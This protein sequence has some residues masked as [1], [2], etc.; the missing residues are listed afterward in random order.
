[1]AE[2]KY[3]SK[4]LTRKVIRLAARGLPQT[5]IAKKL[6]ISPKVVSQKIDAELLRWEV[7]SAKI[8]DAYMV[9]DLERI[10]NLLEIAIDSYEE[11]QKV[12]VLQGIASLL[13]T[14]GKLAAIAGRGVEGVEDDKYSLTINV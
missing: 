9:A 2:I 11:D 1:M 12:G 10:D 4:E 6:G 14:R 8:F 7:E 5:E 3:T 13:Q